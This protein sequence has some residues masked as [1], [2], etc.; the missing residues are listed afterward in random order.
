MPLQ[1][2]DTDEVG[3]VL[4]PRVFGHLAGGTC[5]HKAPALHD[6]QSIGECG[7]LQGVVC[8]D[9]AEARKGSEVMLEVTANLRT[10]RDVQSG[11]RLIEQ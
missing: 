5:L 10:R 9:E 8:D 3:D 7:S 11:Q 4:G 1:Q 6:D 2:I